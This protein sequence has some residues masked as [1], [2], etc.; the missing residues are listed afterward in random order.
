MGPV[1]I[2]IIVLAAAAVAGLILSYIIRKVKGKSSGCG[3]CAGCP[4]AG[5]CSHSAKKTC[6]TDDAQGK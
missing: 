1:E 5:Q 2:V 3:G 4:Y 6:K